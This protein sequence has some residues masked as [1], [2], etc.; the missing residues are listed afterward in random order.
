MLVHWVGA[1]YVNVIGKFAVLKFRVKEKWNQLNIFLNNLASLTVQ[2]SDSGGQRKCEVHQKVNESDNR[3]KA[4]DKFP[5]EEFESVTDPD[6]FAVEKELYLASLCEVHQSA[7][8]WYF[9]MFMLKNGNFDKNTTI[10][11]ENGKHVS[12]IITSRN[13]PCFG[14]GCMNQPLI[15]HNYSRLVYSGSQALYLNGGFFGTY[16]LDA[17]LSRGVG[18]NSFFSISWKKNLG[19]GSWIFSHK[20][21]TSAKYPW[22]M[23]YL[24]SDA[25]EGFNGGYHYKGCGIMSK[26]C[27]HIYSICIHV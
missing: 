9:W 11:P 18:N 7:K 10:C 27:C 25:T 23:L 21:T 3:L 24:R 6:L 8:P 15:Y 16:D 4:G 22:L 26:V 19:T 14:K 13:F 2:L 17:D 20:L 12:K 1:A 5:A